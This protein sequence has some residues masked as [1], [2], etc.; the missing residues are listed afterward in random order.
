MFHKHYNLG[1]IES[2]CVVAKPMG[3]LK[4]GLKWDQ[5][6]EVGVTLEVEVE[7]EAEVGMD[8]GG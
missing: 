6:V 2:G 5:E 8:R 7:V 1:F 4:T 3:L